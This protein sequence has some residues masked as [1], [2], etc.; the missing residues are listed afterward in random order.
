M[1]HHDACRTSTCGDVRRSVSTRVD[2]R[3]DAAF[4]THV[5][6][7]YVNGPLRS[8]DVL[9]LFCAC[10]F[11]RQIYQKIL[12]YTSRYLVLITTADSNAVKRQF[13]S[14]INNDH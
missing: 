11:Y 9:W 3:H 5:D 4:L 12:Y 13:L 6:V 7:R 1:P 8:K 10:Y 2:V 14:V